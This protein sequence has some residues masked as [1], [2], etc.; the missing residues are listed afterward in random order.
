M[1]K[2]I[3]LNLLFVT[4]LTL[5]TLIQ[6]LVTAQTERDEPLGETIICGELDW[7]DWSQLW[8]IGPSTLF[9]VE[10]DWHPSQVQLY[11]YI[12]DDE[13]VIVKDLLVNGYVERMYDTYPRIGIYLV[14]RY[15][16]F[17]LDYGTVYY[18]G[19]ISWCGE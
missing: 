14:L 12:Y 4:L 6:I 13:G 19:L 8:D 18:Y 17:Q 1:K 9:A 11:L 5:S 2:K 10:I 16:K 15:H 3:F 7:G